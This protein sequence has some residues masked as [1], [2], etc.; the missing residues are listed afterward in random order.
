MMT[1]SSRYR[2]DLVRTVGAYRF[3]AGKSTTLSIPP[4]PLRLLAA[5][6]SILISLATL[7]IVS[8]AN[9][10]T[11][12]TLNGL[13]TF[14]TRG[15][16]SIQPVAGAGPS[17]S[18]GLSPYTGYEVRISAPGATNAWFPGETTQDT[19]TT[20]STNGFNMRGKRR[21]YYDAQELPP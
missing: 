16:G 10:A 20:G 5:K 17:D 14:G 15:D 19:R 6:A 11:T 18:I 3:T 21:T 1:V 9:G 7:A 13:N 4:V 12:F 2:I 8:A